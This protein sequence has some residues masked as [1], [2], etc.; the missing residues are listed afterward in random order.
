MVN[1][2]AQFFVSFSRQM[3]VIKHVLM[4]YDSITPYKAW[5]GDEVNWVGD[6]LNGFLQCVVYL[7]VFLTKGVG[8]FSSRKQTLKTK[9]NIDN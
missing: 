3:K 5:I 4:A 7:E 6:G 8:L 1:V 2:L 9:N